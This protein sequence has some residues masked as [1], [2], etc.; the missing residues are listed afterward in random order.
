MTATIHVDYDST[1]KKVLISFFINENPSKTAAAFI[2]CIANRNKQIL[3]FVRQRRGK[4]ASQQ[5]FFFWFELTWGGFFQT[6]ALRMK[7]NI[8]RAQNW[9]RNRRVKSQIDKT[10]LD[11]VAVF[12]FMQNLKMRI[13]DWK[14]FTWKGIFWRVHP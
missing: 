4:M 9:R 7:I 6:I 12:H 13:S 2:F 3:C 14:R 11:L 5:F 8:E 1:G 10:N